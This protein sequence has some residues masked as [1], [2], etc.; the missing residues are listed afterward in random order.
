M[1]LL[2][3]L[4]LNECVPAVS[5]EYHMALESEANTVKGRVEDKEELNQDD[6]LNPLTEIYLLLSTH[7]LFNYI[8]Q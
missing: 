5:G 2:L 8:S 7:G 6:S 3:N 4:N 1:P